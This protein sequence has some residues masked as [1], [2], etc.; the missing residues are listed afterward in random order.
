[1]TSGLVE[2]VSAL[3]LVLAIEGVLYAAFPG[4]MRRMLASLSEQPEQGLRF[5]GLISLM[6][7]VLIVWMVR[8]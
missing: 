7:G 6:A 5:A 1:M 4:F 3:G 8:G 2:L